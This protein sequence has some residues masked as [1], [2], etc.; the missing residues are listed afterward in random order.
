MCL[1][2]VRCVFVG[3]VRLL[4]CGV[5]VEKCVCFSFFP[6]L[7]GG[8]MVGLLVVWFVPLLLSFVAMPGL[9][10]FL[11]L[12]LITILFTHVHVTVV[13]TKCQGT[14]A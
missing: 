10:R 3:K 14:H 8:C 13:M 9:C 5:S 6:C 12:T 4:L 2:V 7:F 1:Y 11:R